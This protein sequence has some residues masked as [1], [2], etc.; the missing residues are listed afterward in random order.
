MKTYRY[1]SAICAGILTLGGCQKPEMETPASQTEGNVVIEAALSD[2]GI[3]TKTQMTP[4]TAEGNY[5]AYSIASHIS[6]SSTEASKPCSASIASAI[7][8]I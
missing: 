8:N 5:T 1:L 2:E 4:G 3:E 6:V 7:V